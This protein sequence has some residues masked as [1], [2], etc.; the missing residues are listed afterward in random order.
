QVFCAPRSKAY[1]SYI[2]LNCFGNLYEQTRAQVQGRV[3]DAKLISSAINKMI[4]GLDPQSSYIDS[5]TWKEQA[6][7]KSGGVGIEVTVQGGMIKVVSSIDDTPASKANILPND[8][9]TQID[10]DD[11][12]GLTL[13]QFVNKVR[14]PVNT[15][16]NFTI[17]RKGKDAPF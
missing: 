6:R 12:Q 10:G 3:S 4:S 2:A 17:V 5:D 15:T 16:A 8:I 13:E 11:V 1:D 7:S 14:G 9:I